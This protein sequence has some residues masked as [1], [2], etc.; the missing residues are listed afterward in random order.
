MLHLTLQSE[1]TAAAM[2]VQCEQ[3]RS[4]SKF[5]FSKHSADFASKEY[6]KRRHGDL[7][8]SD[9]KQKEMGRVRNVSWALNPIKQAFVISMAFMNLITSMTCPSEYITLALR[10][11]S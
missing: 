8:D 6:S 9:D 5:L 2:T 11:H 10:G 3:T 7:W 1:G 4:V